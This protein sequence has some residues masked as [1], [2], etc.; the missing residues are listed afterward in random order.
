MPA[1]P[2]DFAALAAGLSLPPT[3]A[4]WAAG[5]EASQ[6]CYPA[7]LPGFLTPAELTAACQRLGLSA[8]LREVMLSALPE[9]TGDPRLCRLLW[10]L[11]RRLFSPHQIRH[12]GSTGLSQLA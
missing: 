3:A 9:V 6:A 4:L 11:Y 8:E 10:H 7:P 12:D 2:F 5:W 1:T